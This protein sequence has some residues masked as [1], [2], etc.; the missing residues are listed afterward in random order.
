MN[1]VELLNELDRRRI[2]LTANNGRLEARPPVRDVV[3][4]DT[5]RRFKTDLLRLLEIKAAVRGRFMARPVKSADPW[6]G[7]QDDRKIVEPV[8]G[9]RMHFRGWAQI[10]FPCSG[11]GAE[12]GPWAHG[13][14]R[15]RMVARFAGRVEDRI[16]LLRAGRI[17]VSVD[18][19]TRSCLFER[20][21]DGNI[22]EFPCHGSW[23]GL[24]GRLTRAAR[25]SHAGRDTRRRWR[26]GIRFG[27]GAS[28]QA[29]AARNRVG[30]PVRHDA[31]EG[32]DGD[33]G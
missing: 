20:K 23:V 18:T 12:S 33:Q 26:F 31:K 30:W 29:I 14:R 11:S 24:T 16:S 6:G 25:S 8:F 1:V 2:G 15:R 27:P 7:S 3:I 22:S 10:E 17:F 9:P 5:I 19:P 32:M 13:F 28:R 4:G 21:L